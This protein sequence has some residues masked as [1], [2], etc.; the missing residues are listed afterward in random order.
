MSE[1]YTIAANARAA[2]PITQAGLPVMA[3]P[4]AVLELVPLCDDVPD[5]CADAP[6]EV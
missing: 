5:V 6:L 1:A 4:P 2:P 3:D